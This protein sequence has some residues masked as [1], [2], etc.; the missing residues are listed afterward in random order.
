MNGHALIG[1]TNE[2]IEEL[3]EKLENNTDELQ[4]TNQQLK[5]L[6]DSNKRSARLQKYLTSAIVLFAISQFSLSLVNNLSFDSDLSKL[7]AIVGIVIAS[8]LG[9]F[10]FM[11]G[12]SIDI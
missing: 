7:S 11:K 8:L 12:T 10:Y 1:S 4:A 6:I 2:K 9:I 5:Q 3:K